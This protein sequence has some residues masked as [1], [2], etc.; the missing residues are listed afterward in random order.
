MARN[1]TPLVRILQTYGIRRVDLAAAAGVDSKTIARL[2]RGEFGGVKMGT[3]ARIAVAL[4]V[5]PAELVPW[6]AVRPTGGGLVG[7]R[8]WRGCPVRC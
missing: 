8:R 1:V 2:C 4:G 7:R 5:A 6:L 3:L